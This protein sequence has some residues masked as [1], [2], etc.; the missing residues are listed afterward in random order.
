MIK[1]HRFLQ[2]GFILQTGKGIDFYD[3]YKSIYI[4]I[5]MCVICVFFSSAD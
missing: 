1:R 4:Y 2:T 3:V 5:D